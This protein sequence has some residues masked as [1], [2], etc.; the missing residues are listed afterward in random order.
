MSKAK[1]TRKEEIE[2]EARERYYE[3]LQCFLTKPSLLTLLKMRDALHF[4]ERTEAAAQQGST[5]SAGQN[6]PLSKKSKTANEVKERFS[7]NKAQA[8]FDGQDLGLPSGAESKPVDILKKLVESFGKVVSYNELDENGES[9]SASDNLRRRVHK[10]N[11]ALKKHKVPCKIKS[12]T[13]E[14]YILHSS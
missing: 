3:S 4:Y 1:R 5:D 6:K 9:T 11:S 8:F 2:E 7:F 13:Y 14:G 12:K 10:I